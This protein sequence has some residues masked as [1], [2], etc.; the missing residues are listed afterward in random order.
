MRKMTGS[1]C[2]LLFVINFQTTCWKSLGVVCSGA[3]GLHACRERPGLLARTAKY[4]HVLQSGVH[5][6]C[7]RVR[8]QICVN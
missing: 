4:I 7:S 2:T 8:T 5:E 3:R 1:A 6:W